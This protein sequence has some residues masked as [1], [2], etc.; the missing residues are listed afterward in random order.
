[1]LHAPIISSPIQPAFFF[2][3][4]RRPPRSTLFPYTTLFRSGTPASIRALPAI[5]EAVGD[6]IEVLLDG[7]IRRGGDV[8]KALALGAK[9]VLI[10]RA[11]LWGLAANGQAGVENA[12]DLIRDGLGSAMVGLGRPSVAELSRDDLVV[13]PGFEQRLGENAV[14][15]AG[16]GS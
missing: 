7:G 12:L 5:A 14:A 3:M 1:M 10:G 6:Q 2:L 16:E 13:P 4:I 15:R 11:Y 8:A 9:A